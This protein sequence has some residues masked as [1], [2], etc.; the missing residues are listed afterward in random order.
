MCTGGKKI[1][2][3]LPN[4]GEKWG[5]LEMLSKG[6]VENDSGEYGYHSFIYYAE[7]QCECGKVFRVPAVRWKGKNITRDCG[8]GLY[9]KVARRVVFSINIRQD[10]REAIAQMA[11]DNQIVE[12]EAMRMIIEAGLNMLGYG[13]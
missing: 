8:C 2:A 9:V 13:G 4:T 10:H 5:C 7:L 3:R 11:A 6:K 1:M 12:S